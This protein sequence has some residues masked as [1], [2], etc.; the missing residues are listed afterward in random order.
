[1]NS[2][3]FRLLHFVRNDGLRQAQPPERHCER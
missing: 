3:Q 1:V 2:E